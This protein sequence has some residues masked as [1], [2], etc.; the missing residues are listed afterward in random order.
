MRLTLRTMAL[1]GLF[2]IGSVLGF[3]TSS[4]KAQGFGYGG[5]HGH[6]GGYGVPASS[7]YGNGGHDFAPHGHTVQ[8]PLGG[9]SYYGNGA[10][11]Y[12][13][14]LNVQTPYGIQ[15]YSNGFF[16]STQSYS[17]PVPYQPW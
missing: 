15:G 8:T 12:R 11:D 10:H 14:H 16:R 6:R 9:Y 13:P 17:P 1:A 4:A 5:H 7:Y 2:T 3:G